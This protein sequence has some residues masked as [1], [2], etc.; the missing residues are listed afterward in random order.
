MKPISILRL[1]TKLRK[2]LNFTATG[3]LIAFVTEL[4]IISLRMNALF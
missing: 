3:S 1:Q 4:L 2:A